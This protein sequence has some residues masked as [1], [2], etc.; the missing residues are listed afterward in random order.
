MTDFFLGVLGYGSAVSTSVIQQ[1]RHGDYTDASGSSI[2]LFARPLGNVIYLM[3]SQITTP[4]DVQECERILLSSLTGT[5]K[6]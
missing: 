3:T 6:V 1:L 4:T 2:N 5:N